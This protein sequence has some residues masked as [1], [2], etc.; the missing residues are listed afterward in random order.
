M[1]KK[2][3]LLIITLVLLILIAGASM[4]Y[5]ILGGDVTA[6]QDSDGSWQQ[7][8]E[9]A[10]KTLA[11][12]FTVYDADGNEVKLSAFRGKPVVLN[13]WA[14]WCGPCKSEMPDFDTKC[15]SLD[16]QV[17]FLM[18]NVTDGSRET[19]ETASAFIAEQGYSFP[20][21]YDTSMSASSTYGATSLPMTYFIDAE[22]YGIAR[23]IGA[24]DE[25]TLQQGIDMIM[26]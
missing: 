12:D 22:G 24:I 7:T 14:S 2:K 17:Q 10:E 23:A 9:S 26:E 11:P 21:Y 20:V 5:H 3:T 13:F 6:E 16:G 15:E 1:N 18:V 25:S 8:D 19:V 4:L